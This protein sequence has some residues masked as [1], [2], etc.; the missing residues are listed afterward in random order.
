[1]TKLILHI[2]LQKTGTTFLQQ[3]LIGRAS[4]LR[5]AGVHYLSPK[6][7]L[8]TEK[9]SAAHHWMVSAVRKMP[10]SYI[11]DVP[12]SFLPQYV[13]N[14]RQKIERNECPVALISSENF[15]RMNDDQVAAVRKHFQ[16][17]D[18][19]VVIYLRRQD[20]WIDSWYAQMVKTGKTIQLEDAL[21]DMADFLDF[22]NLINRWGNSFGRKNIRLGI[23]E[24]LN[25]P[26]DLWRDFFTLIGCPSAASI[27][28]QEESANVTLS[29]QLTKFIEIAQET[30]GYNPQLRRFLERVNENFEP[31]K[32]LKF[33]SE[34]RAHELLESY[35]EANQ[36]IAKEFFDRDHL[37]ANMDVVGS[38]TDQS[39]SI[40]D[41]VKI[42][43]G[44]NI[45]LLKRISDLEKKIARKER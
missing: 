31:S 30:T 20:I 28:L 29:S 23:Y 13:A 15:S 6:G 37:F 8:P 44:S 5:E 41:I 45:A 10:T 19:E 34:V 24:N 16:G 26:T 12:F 9:V 25:S 40:E 14:M 18:T 32:S 11:P 35:A 22:R 27:K 33:I 1:M 43:A 2:G 17:I 3:N 7:N 36:E 42:M 21:K 39:L 38:D 4:L